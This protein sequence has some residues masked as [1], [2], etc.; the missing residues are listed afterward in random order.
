MGLW[1]CKFEPKPDWNRRKQ[2]MLKGLPPP[3]LIIFA[4]SS[5]VRGVPGP[6]LGPTLL[7]SVQRFRSKDFLSSHANHPF[8]NSF[9]SSAGELQD[10]LHA[11]EQLSHSLNLH[12]STSL[13]NPKLVSMLRQEADILH[14]LHLSDQNIRQTVTA[15]R[16]RSGASYGEDV[17]TD[18]SIV[19]EW[20]ISRLEAWGTLVGMETFKEDHER[21]GRMTFVLGGKVLV[22]DIELSVDRNSLDGIPRI[23]LNGL[24]TSYATPNGAAGDGATSNTEGSASLDA[25]LASSVRTFLDEVQRDTDLV[26]AMEA[27]RLGKVVLEQ[28]RYLV[29]L[30]KIAANKEEAGG[31]MRWFI[32]ID[33]LGSTTE[34]FGSSEA[35]AI[36]STLSLPSAPVDIYLNRSHGLP[37]PYLMS[38]SLS[39][40]IHL[41]PSAYLSALRSTPTAAP[42]SPLN[43]NLPKLDIPLTHLR[44]C[45]S[46]HPRP[47]GITVATL[48][49]EPSGPSD[50][51]L[52]LI[53]ADAA[54]RDRPTFSLAQPDDTRPFPQLPPNLQENGLAHNDYS[55]TLDF[56]SFG[57]STGLVMS[58]SRMHEIE[59]I[60]HSGANVG[61]MSD[62]GLMN[63]GSVSH[64]RDWVDML[65][66]T[67]L[68]G[69]QVPSMPKKY[70]TLYR[71]PSS[72]HP[73]LRLRLTPPD[74]AGFLLEKVRVKNMHEVWGIFEVVREQCWI[75]AILT[76]SEWTIANS[77]V[78]QPPEEPAPNLVNDAI[79][80]ALLKG[81][82]PPNEIPVEVFF[83]SIAHPNFPSVADLGFDL[84]D[85]VHGSHREPPRITMTLPERPPLT[86]FTEIV[87]SY[88]QA[89]AKGVKVEIGGR[90]GMEGSGVNAEVL[91]EVCRR[92]GALGLAGRV[93]KGSDMVM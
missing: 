62:L 70:T 52:S 46:A 53:G 7:S 44:Q 14:K 48:S 42:S 76:S 28:L 36:A 63:F 37:L 6:A 9:T 80:D 72:A 73:P 54:Q 85:A 82:H 30:D 67:A 34:K 59:R 8:S 84:A 61:G 27:E 91:E 51:P 20:A 89:K 41:T 18:R 57:K 33:V 66:G 81:T 93:W 17:P 1:Y 24:K 58:Q 87:I 38:P 10:L 43:A 15:L 22:I 11:T 26:D 21:E 35:G 13:S 78:S 47:K 16:S 56:T 40:L 31:G 68:D 25:L 49:L 71:S 12:A 77:L 5:Q 90:M 60:L 4:M 19:A 75:N 74:E 65:L 3:D 79:L 2:Y 45:L 32:D 55:W 69:S 23:T 39:F 83:P 88:D 29:I 50:D 64:D 92:G 86:G